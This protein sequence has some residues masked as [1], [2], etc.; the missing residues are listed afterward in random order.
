M[1]FLSLGE[2]FIGGKDTGMSAKFQ[3]ADLHWEHGVD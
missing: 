3:W 2:A 1:G